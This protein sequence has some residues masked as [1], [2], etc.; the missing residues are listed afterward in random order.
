M[1]HT[2]MRTRSHTPPGVKVT[3]RRAG[4]STRQNAEDWKGNMY[5]CPSEKV[6]SSSWNLL[7][8]VGWGE[9]SQTYRRHPLQSTDDFACKLNMSARLYVE[10]RKILY[11]GFVPNQ[12]I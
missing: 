8:G 7:L 12:S 5:I 2:F 3:R 6:T 4:Q 11:T 1:S 10:H 9:I